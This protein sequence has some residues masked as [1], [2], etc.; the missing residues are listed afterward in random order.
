MPTTRCKVGDASA[1]RQRGDSYWLDRK[2]GN[3]TLTT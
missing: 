1:G 2:E 3:E